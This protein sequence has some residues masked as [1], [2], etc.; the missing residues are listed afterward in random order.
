VRKIRG[1]KNAEWLVE[2][3]KFKENIKTAAQK[4]GLRYEKRVQSMLKWTY[5]DEGEVRLGP[6]ISFKDSFG[7][8]ICQPD[9]VVIP[10]DK[11]KPVIVIEAKLSCVKGA[12]AKLK[13]LYGRLVSHILE[14]KVSYV[15]VYKNK[16]G[17]ER[18][19]DF[20]GFLTLRAGEYRECHYV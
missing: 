1:L 14:R 6:W 12:R 17:V 15:Q 7:A 5:G 19:V 20:T 13:S 11:S 9:A 16:V 8:S 10:F 4:T 18:S 3:P 2:A